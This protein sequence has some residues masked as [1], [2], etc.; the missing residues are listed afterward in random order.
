MS[1]FSLL[2]FVILLFGCSEDDNA[3]QSPLSINHSSL[4]ETFVLINTGPTT[5]TERMIVEVGEFP[6]TLGTGRR[7]IQ[8]VRSPFAGILFFDL[9]PGTRYQY[10]VANGC[11]DGS[12]SDFFGPQSFTTLEEGEGCTAPTNLTAVKITSTT[13]DITWEANGEDAWVIKVYDEF[14]QIFRDFATPFTEFT[15]DELIPGSSYKIIVSAPCSGT[16]V[17]LESNELFITTL[18]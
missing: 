18:D 4:D 5:R 2:V 3:C 6:L 10:Y 1:R 9:N 16:S 12:M 11:E 15:V 13:V 14:D 8:E 17:S 7:K